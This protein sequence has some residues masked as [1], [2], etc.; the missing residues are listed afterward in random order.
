[1]S[2]L[3]IPTAPVTSLPPSTFWGRQEP[4]SHPSCAQKDVSD[5]LT[6]EWQPRKSCDSQ[7][8]GTCRSDA[9]L[10]RNLWAL[11]PPSL[12]MLLLETQRTQPGNKGS[13]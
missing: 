7:W 1:M 11:E 3:C 2:G 6:R 10:G 9:T 4:Q 5:S 13:A 8:T 12:G